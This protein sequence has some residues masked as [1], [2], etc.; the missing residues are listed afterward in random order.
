MFT[1]P[2]DD[3]MSSLLWHDRVE[4]RLTR[5]RRQSRL[6]SP[7]VVAVSGGSDSV[8]L[9]RVLHEFRSQLGLDLSVAHLDHGTRSTSADDA[10]FVAELARSLELPFE[11][12]HWKPTRQAH[13]EADARRARYSW[14]TEVAT[15]RGASAV[16]VGH[17]RDD[18]AETILHRILRGTGPLGLRG[19]A[20][21]RPLTESVSLIRPLLDCSREDLRHYLIAIDQPWREDP[22][23]LDQSRTRSRL[24]HDLIPKLSAEYNPKVNDALVRL[25]QFIAAERRGFEALIGRVESQLVRET[26]DQTISIDLRKG[27]ELPPIVLIEILRRA[28]RSAHWPERE[29][30]AKRWMRLGQFFGRERARISVGMGVEASIEAGVLRLSRGFDPPVE[31]LPCV[32]LPIPGQAEW[33]GGRIRLRLIPL[34]A[35]VEVSDSC[36]TETID[37]AKIVPPLVVHPPLPGDRFEPLGMYG[38]TTPL[39]DFLRGRGLKKT[40]RS[41]IPILRDQAGIVWVVGHRIAERVRLSET[42]RDLLE[43]RWTSSCD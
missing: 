36:S 38:Q 15:K 1:Q 32:D 33:R 9:L 31:V 30:T 13:F 35:P 7:W 23:N 16:V 11:L 10:E 14:L 27:L 26:S 34:G 6:A 37:L 22:T 41:R 2:L 29:M 4:R 20:S 25:G 21:R 12:G 28:W 17:T 39:A 18:Q 43:L 3:A 24:R 19:I 42:T 5:W 8:G 40:D